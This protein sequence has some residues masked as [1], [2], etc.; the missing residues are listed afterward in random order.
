MRSYLT[1]CPAK[2]KALIPGPDDVYFSDAFRQDLLNFSELEGLVC[3]G[4][5]FQA[6]SE[7][8]SF[9][10]VVKLQTGRRLRLSKREGS[11]THLV[12]LYVCILKSRFSFV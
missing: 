2:H 7:E 3:E 6:D 11:K 12:C 4:V 10:D 5:F 9:Q 1:L 8:G